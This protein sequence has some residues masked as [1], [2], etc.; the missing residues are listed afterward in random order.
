MRYLLSYA[1]NL[2]NLTG[3]NNAGREELVESSVRTLLHELVKISSGS[4]GFNATKSSA[5]HA[6][7]G[8]E[9]SQKHSQQTIEMKKGDWLCPK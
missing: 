6:R 5:R 3:G 4:R 7:F 8:Y 1:W 9:E 2:L